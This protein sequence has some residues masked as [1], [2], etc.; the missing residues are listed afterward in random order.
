MENIS[1]SKP[2][3]ASEDIDAVIRVMQSNMIAEGGLAQKFELAV[4]QFMGL[5]GGVATSSGTAALILALKAM[6]VGKQDEVILPTYVCRA[7]RDAVVGVG[8]KP[9]LC[10]VS[11]DDWCMSVDTVTPHITGRTKAIIVV[12]IFGITADIIPLTQL[13]VP[14]IED[15]CQAFGAIREGQMAGTFGDCCFLS[16]HA[17]KLLTT[18]E[19]GMVLT[20]NADL[21]ARVGRVKDGHYGPLKERFRYPLSDIQAAL[22][23]SQ[24]G[25]YQSFLERRRRIADYYFDTLAELSAQL[26]FGVRG[27]SIFFRFPLR[28]REEY[29]KLR[30]RFNESKIQVRRGVDELLHIQENKQGVSHP[31]G[32]R[33]YA[34]TVSIPIYPALK[35]NEI[36]YVAGVCKKIF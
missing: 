26:P 21:L 28:V 6:G 4:S 27:H 14:I 12:H 29:E 2:L 31:Q 8:A 15:C 35:D 22:G 34:E 30:D 3:I 13:G 25:R 23:L 20:G 1:H 17:T 16:F 7:V 19:G 18:G 9:V 32:E 24:L 33:L 11:A 10:D 36:E 5:R